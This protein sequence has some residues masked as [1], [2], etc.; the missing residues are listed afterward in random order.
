MLVLN[1]DFYQRPFII[2]TALL[3]VQMN[4]ALRNHNVKYKRQ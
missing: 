2:Y 3:K 4:V 1:N